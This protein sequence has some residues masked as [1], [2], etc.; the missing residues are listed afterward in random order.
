MTELVENSVLKE[1]LTTQIDG[2]RD[3]FAP[4]S[5]HKRRADIHV[6]QA[7]WK[8]RVPLKD[9]SSVTRR[10]QWAILGGIGV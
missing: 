8:I 2:K 3:H 6:R 5:E 7:G 1:S 4:S 9:L 10:V